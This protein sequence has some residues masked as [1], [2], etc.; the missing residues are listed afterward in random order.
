MKKIICII[1][2]SLTLAGCKTAYVSS[3]SDK[4]LSNY[5]QK[6]DL[7]KVTYEGGDGKTMETAIIVKAANE[8]DGIAAEYAYVATLY[9]QVRSNWNLVAQYSSSKN[10]KQYDVLKIKL[11]KN[12]QIVEIYFDITEFYGKF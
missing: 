11:T 7:S 2:I 10:N 1:L 9:G 6:P 3:Q 5:S 8:R 4:P 12:D